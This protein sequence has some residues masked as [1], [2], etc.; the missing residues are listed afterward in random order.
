MIFYSMFKLKITLKYKKLL[1]GFKCIERYNN[2][3]WL[4][5]KMVQDLLAIKKHYIDYLD[6]SNDFVITEQ[7]CLEPYDF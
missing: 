7:Q 2:I 1:E 6:V 4:K 3:S 5:Q